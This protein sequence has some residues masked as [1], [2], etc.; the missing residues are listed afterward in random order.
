MF[1]ESLLK[2]SDTRDKFI[3]EITLFKGNSDETKELLKIFKIDF[4]LNIAICVLMSH[5]VTVL[6]Q[7]KQVVI[8][9][10]ENKGWLTTDNPVHLD[11]N[12]HHEWI[13]PIESEIYFP[14]SKDFCLFMYH[15]KAKI[16][17]N[18]LRKL[19]INKVNKIHFPLFEDIT[20]RN[21]LNL[22]EYMIMP[23]EL[24][25]TDVTGG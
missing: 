21:V 11:K 17:S 24:E 15:D 2:T 3:N 14:L 16:D 19:K 9:D 4:Q 13:L 5:M 25:E 12:G 22:D 1:I 18:P 8:K 23:I 20:K 10:C 7:F 6:R